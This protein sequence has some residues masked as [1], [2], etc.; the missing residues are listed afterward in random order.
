MSLDMLEKEYRWL[1]ELRSDAQ[2][3]WNGPSHEIKI[4]FV[5]LDPAGPLF[6]GRDPLV[7]LD[8]TDAYYVDVIHTDGTGF[9]MLS[10]VGHVDF[11]PNLGQNQPGCNASIPGLLF[12]LIKGEIKEMKNDI[13]CSHMRAPSLFTE[14][15]NSRC[16]FF[17][18][19]NENDVKCDTV[20]SVMG[21]DV[22]RKEPSGDRFLHTK[23]SEP[24]CSEYLQKNPI[25]YM[26]RC[27][28]PY[29]LHALILPALT[30]TC[31]HASILISFKM[32]CFQSYQLHAA[33]LLA[34]SVVR[35]R[36][37]IPMSYMLHCFQ[38]HQLYVACF[39]PYQLH[40]VMLPALSSP[41]CHASSPIS[42]ML[43]CL[44]P[45]Q[46]YAAMLPALSGPCCH[47][48][49]PISCI[50]PCFQPYQLHNG[51]LPALSAT[52]CHASSPISYMLS[53][54]QPYQLY[55]VML[56]TISAICCYASSSIGYMLSL[57]QSFQRHAVMLPAL[58]AT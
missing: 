16:R 26:T 14:S 17:S 40:A 13:S 52:N 2:N 58:S 10:P 35:C 48:S 56:L 43:P 1:H 15:I 36:A 47:A 44:Q 19:P 24:F 11:Y 50:L 33:M 34:L 4:S 6:E 8:S 39:Q 25:S 55:V 53:C 5:G 46:L 54:F 23:S 18:F 12:K 57:F 51:M 9:G 27:F 45:Y 3:V 30:A 38:P 28:Q 41:C 22:P 29:Q 32:P 31:C 42:Y 20:C 7:R 37:S 21:Y 49:S